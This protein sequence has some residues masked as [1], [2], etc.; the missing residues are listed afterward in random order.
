MEDS[1]D[2]GEQSEDDEGRDEGDDA[3]TADARTRA[4]AVAIAAEAAAEA[5]V[6]EVEADA[7]EEEQVARAYLLVVPPSLRCTP[8]FPLLLVLR[9]SPDNFCRDDSGGTT[10]R[11]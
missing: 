11:H 5:A 2:P 3:A 1:A 7:A 9:Y 6:A 4:E 10:C 8:P